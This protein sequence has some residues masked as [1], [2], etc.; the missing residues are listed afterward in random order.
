MTDNIFRQAKELLDKR[1]A[2][3]QITWDEF[4]L[5]NTAKIPL[6]IHGCPFPED[7]TVAECLEKLAKILEGEEK[8]D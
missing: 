6:N 2:G 7:M 4:Q 1:A 8:I 3:N 5:I